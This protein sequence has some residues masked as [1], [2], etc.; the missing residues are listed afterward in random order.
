MLLFLTELPFWA[1]IPLLVVLPAMLAMIGAVFVRRCVGVEKLAINN[2]VAD[3]KFATVGVI[4]AVVAAFAVIVV[5]EKL[6]D[7]QAAV[8]QEAGAAGTL[9]RLTGGPD[10]KM[11][12][13]RSAL[14]HYLKLAIEKD[15]PQMAAEKESNEATE[16]LNAL[17]AA[18]LPLI[19]DTSRHTAL[20]VE[21][22][23]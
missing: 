23:K 10:R 17:Y 7:A 8:V 15:W 9:Y 18:A 5:W 3:F 11:T 4:Y 13:V 21:I 16:A 22:F 6:S 2:E 14:S 1:S 19:E 12:A 20:L